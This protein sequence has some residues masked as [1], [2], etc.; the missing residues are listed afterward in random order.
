MTCDD[1]SR[2]PSGKIYSH[3]LA[4]FNFRDSS[5]TVITTALVSAR[6][7]HFFQPALALHL[8]RLDNEDYEHQNV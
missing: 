3:L 8:R 5:G 4:S 1:A 2:E 6:P 7:T